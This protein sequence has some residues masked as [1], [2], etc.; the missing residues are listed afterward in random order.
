MRAGGQNYS[1]RKESNLLTACLNYLAVL[2]NKKE[3]VWVDRLN[4]GKIF[5]G[6]YMIRLCRKGTP[7]AYMLLNNGKI[8]FL[9]TKFSTDLSPEQRDFKIRVEGV[10]HQ[11][12]IVKNID[13][14]IRNLTKN[15]KETV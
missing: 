3:I 14:L 10:G 6:K 9:E 12:W 5:T 1:K 11:Y 8:I 13:D 4:S 15:L 2:E 7:D